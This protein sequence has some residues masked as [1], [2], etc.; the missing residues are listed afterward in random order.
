MPPQVRAHPE[1]QEQA[2]VGCQHVLREIFRA[3]GV[4]FGA[5]ADGRRGGVLQSGADARSGPPGLEV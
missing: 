1:Q 2:V 5:R 3:N 4:G